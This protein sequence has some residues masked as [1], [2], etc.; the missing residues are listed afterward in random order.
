MRIRWIAGA[1]LIAM[2]IGLGPGPANAESESGGVVIAS[3]TKGGYYH[4]FAR[5]L[6]VVLFN[7]YGIPTDVRTS[8][9][10]MKNLALLDDPDSLVNVALAQ[11]DALESHLAL[12][13]GFADDYVQIGDAGKECAF[14]VAG[15]RSGIDGL[16]ALA[17][18]TD[19]SIA[20]G[21]AGSGAAITWMNLARLQPELDAVKAVDQGT[22]EALLALQAG[23]AARGP[24]ATMMVQRPMAVATPLEI[25]LRNAD[26]LA[27]VPIEQSDLPSDVHGTDSPVYTFEK[28]VVGL[29]RN[30]QA[31]VDTLCTRALVLAA[32]KKLSASELEVIRKAVVKSRQYV[33][34]GN[35]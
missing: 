8:S 17:K 28:I 7:E 15:R 29:G 13:P 32:R 26:E 18:A 1:A 3:G 31:S 24:T 2:G 27:L 23:E 6:R 12:H 33:T 22:I 14:I 9:G 16:A 11:A 19:P 5:S 30:Q 21:E 25:V 10:S 35:P 20:I 4:A 34:S